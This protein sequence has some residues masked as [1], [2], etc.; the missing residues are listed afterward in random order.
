MFMHPYNSGTVKTMRDAAIPANLVNLG[1]AAGIV[2]TGTGSTTGRLEFYLANRLQMYID[3]A[4]I[5]T[6]GSLIANLGVRMGIA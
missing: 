3:N 4:G 2:D 1:G 6:R 5:W